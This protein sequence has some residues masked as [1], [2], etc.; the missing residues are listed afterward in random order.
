MTFFGHLFGWNLVISITLFLFLPVLSS[1]FLDKIYILF[2]SPYCLVL[3]SMQYSNIMFGTL[4]NCSLFIHV[5]L[6][7]TMNLCQAKNYIFVIYI[8][9]RLL[10]DIQWMDKK[11]WPHDNTVFVLKCQKFQNNSEI[12]TVLSR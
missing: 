4:D 3:E 2:W 9:Q 6:F 12:F 1:D 11:T 5:L 8:Y 7:V 10:I